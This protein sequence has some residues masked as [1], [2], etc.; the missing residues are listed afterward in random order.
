MGLSNLQTERIWGAMMNLEGAKKLDPPHL[1]PL[2]KRG[3]DGGGVFWPFFFFLA[4]VPVPSTSWE[5]GNLEVE[6]N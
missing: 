5:V 1:T 6:K 2:K 3:G 4:K